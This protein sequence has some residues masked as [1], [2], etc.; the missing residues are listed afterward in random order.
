MIARTWHITFQKDPFPRYILIRVGN[1]YC[2]EQRFGVWMLWIINSVFGHTYTVE[3]D[4]V[5]GGGEGL[6]L[7]YR[8]TPASN[9]LSVLI[10]AVLLGGIGTS[11]FLAALVYLLYCLYRHHL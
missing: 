5:A 11:S 1:R 3:A 8:P 2:G 4:E 9:I 10:P 7:Y 6:F